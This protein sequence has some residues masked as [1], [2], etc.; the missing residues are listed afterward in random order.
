MSRQIALSSLKSLWVHK[1]VFAGSAFYPFILYALIVWLAGPT[2]QPTLTGSLLPFLI[3]PYF[4]RLVNNCH[5]KLLLDENPRS[6]FLDPRL[7]T[8]DFYL[9]IVY[10]LLK[11]AMK[12]SDLAIDA[13]TAQYGNLALMGYV[14]LAGGVLYGG[15]RY[16]FVLPNISLGETKPFRKSLEASL[17]NEWMISSTFMWIVIPFYIFSLGIIL[18]AIFIFD[19]L[20]GDSAYL[21]SALIVVFF[22][23]FSAVL[24]SSV[25]SHL[26]AAIHKTNRPQISG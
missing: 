21:Y 17:G 19:N 24:Y 1:Y 10:I 26:L 18:A 7:S 11:M 8:R 3:A 25:A 9:L 23:V 22:Y 15:C 14:L 5:R 2:P 20:F 12:V 4:G 6:T 16:I 13:I